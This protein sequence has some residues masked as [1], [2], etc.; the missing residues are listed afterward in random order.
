ML[1]DSHQVSQFSHFKRPKH[2]SASLTE[3]ERRDRRVHTGHT[4]LTVNS[5]TGTG[6]FAEGVGTSW[7]SCPRRC[8]RLPTCRWT[9]PTFPSNCS[10]R[11]RVSFSHELLQL[12]LNTKP[13]FCSNRWFLTPK[14][15]KLQM[16]SIVS[17]TT[18]GLSPWMKRGTWKVNEE[19]KLDS[20]D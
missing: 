20:G 16:K 13:L 12:L 1:L 19:V 10:V 4:Q 2:V 8:P 7:I 5:S 11:S 15:R 17:R 14:R 18:A 6:R 9:E 3:R